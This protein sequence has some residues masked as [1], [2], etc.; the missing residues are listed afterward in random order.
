MG[1]VPSHPIPALVPTAS[2]M[3][4]G[5]NPA[6]PWPWGPATGPTAFRGPRASAVPTWTRAPAAPAQLPSTTTLSMETGSSFQQL[7]MQQPLEPPGQ[8][9]LGY[10]KCSTAGSD[11]GKDVGKAA[12][13]SGGSGIGKGP[14]P[15][16]CS[17]VCGNPYA[18]LVSHLR[19]S[20]LSG[21]TRPLEYRTAQLEALGRFL[22][23]KKEE[24]LEATAADMGKPSFEAY[25]SEILLCKNELNVTLNNLCH[26]MKDEH[27]DKNLVMQLD[28]A[29]I[30]KDPYGVVLIISPWNYPIHLFLVPL[31]GAI[32]AG[33]C[34][35]VKPS[36]ISKNTERLVAETL[37]CYLDNDCFAV[38]T[39]GVQE[40]T[41]LLE[42]KFDYIFFTGSPRVGRIVMT[43]AAKHLTPVTLELGDMRKMRFRE[44]FHR[45]WVLRD[46]SWQEVQGVISNLSVRLVPSGFFSAAPTIL[47]DVQP[48][49]PVMQEE[50]FGPILPIVV[51]ANMDEAIDFIN[52]RERPLAIYAFSSSDKVVN[53]VLERTSSGGFCG[54]DTLMH[55]TLTSLPFGGIGNS[56]LGRYHGKFT[57][58]TFSH[59]RGCLHRSMG[60]EAINAPRYPPYTQQ[61]LGLLTAAFEV[62]RRGTCT[63]L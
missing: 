23:D 47:A 11:P 15:L 10:G 8:Q 54:N 61:K 34:V 30:R 60:L 45:N 22:D 25:F 57:F 31:I 24:I 7:G 35:I 19:A 1:E 43:A 12:G 3:E 29:F 59:H 63:L 18:G 13:C 49:D 2:P 16:V 56:G 33:N 52:S 39:G 5:P 14:V 62:K 38:V 58:D 9:P 51:V 44:G 41:R 46:G 28:S 32:A 27:V 40:S 53:Q 42:N 17:T 48:S 37:S 50:I 55:V 20:W 26:W 36:E 21:K 4:A 6:R